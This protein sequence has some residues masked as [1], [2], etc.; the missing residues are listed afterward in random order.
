MQF[1]AAATVLLAS[2]GTGV[3]VAHRGLGLSPDLRGRASAFALGFGLLAVVA[4]G[5]GRTGRFEPRLLAAIALTGAALGLLA[6]V[7]DAPRVVSSWRAAG[8]G[9]W[10]VAATVVVVSYYVLLASAPP[11]SGDALTYHL[12]AP[13]I[14][15]AE[16]RVT[17]LWWES[18]TTFQP[19]AVQMH[20]AY[21]LALAGGG[22]ATAVGAALSGLG[23]ACVYGLARALVSPGVAALAA[24]LWVCQGIFLWEATGAFVDLVT[25][26]FVALGAWHVVELLRGDRSAAGWAGLAA[27]LAASTKYFGLLAVAA[28]GAATALGIRAGSRARLAAAALFALA[29][30]AVALPWYVKNALVTG[31][32]F[33]PALA[34]VLGARYWGP[35]GERYLLEKDEARGVD[36]LWRLPLLPLEFVLHRDRFD[37]GYSISPAFALLAPLALAFNRRWAPVLAAAAAAYAVFWFEVLLQIP[38]YL[39]PVLPFA[40]VLAAFAVVQLWRRGGWARRYAVVAVAVSAAPFLAMTAAFSRQILPGALGLEPERVYV[41]RLT[42]TY[43]AFR[44]V[45]AHLPP[46]GRIFV[47]WGGLYWLDRPYA[48]YSQPFFGWGTPTAET[49][50][51]MRL[52][53]VRFLMFRKDRLPEALAGLR[54]ELRPIAELEFAHV[55]SRTLGR[56]EPDTFVVYRW[57]GAP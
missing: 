49:V 51:R 54:P 32:P 56:A 6:V 48:T 25:A 53:D 34:D 26:A 44:W 30:A 36:G 43:D 27:G 14:W 12:A 37:R 19:F 1:L 23:A 45:D 29:A 52:I 39:L 2:Y 13:K 17:D 11:T 5:L 28:L 35:A 21:A 18:F 24:L 8:A 7:R 10:A 46:E 4:F 50:E 22:A 20:Y 16:G 41:Q 33:Y 15:L 31:D 3:A 9:R 47:G 38:R 40:A 57:T 55:T 42:G